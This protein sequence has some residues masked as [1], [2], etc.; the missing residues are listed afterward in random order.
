MDPKQILN[1]VF[2]VI[3]GDCGKPFIYFVDKLG[4][5]IEG[6]DTLLTEP[7]VVYILKKILEFFGFE[8]QYTLSNLSYLLQPTAESDIYQLKFIEFYH[9]VKL[10]KIAGKTNFH[11]EIHAVEA[12]FNPIFKS[13]L[14]SF[15]AANILLSSSF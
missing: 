13:L 1:N 14:V 6:E 7:Q 3:N 9:K 4:Q 11:L 10:T 2:A 15:C 5:D 8:V 12:F